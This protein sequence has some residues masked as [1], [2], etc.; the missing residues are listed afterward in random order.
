[1]SVIG[2]A[3][4]P[5]GRCAPVDT[6]ST[7]RRDHNNG[8]DGNDRAVVDQGDDVVARIFRGGRIEAIALERHHQGGNGLPPALADAGQERLGF[9]ADD[10]RQ[11]VHDEV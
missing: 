10:L 3:E 11:Y 9:G 1:M 6:T 4:P 8:A 5:W 7:L 2:L